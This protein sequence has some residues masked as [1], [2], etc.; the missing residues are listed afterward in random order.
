MPH[1]PGQMPEHLKLGSSVLTLSSTKYQVALTARNED[2]ATLLLVA[3]N[4]DGVQIR[5]LDGTAVGDLVI[6]PYRFKGGRVP[7]STAPLR[8]RLQARARNLKLEDVRNDFW[9]L[10]RGSNVGADGADLSAFRNARYRC[11][12]GQLRV[13]CMEGTASPHRPLLRNIAAKVYGRLHRVP[14]RSMQYGA[15]GVEQDV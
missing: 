13:A 2:P 14:R 7:R 5:A 11:R 3:W 8:V 10:A 12:D 1:F 15:R 4:D 9:L 6:F